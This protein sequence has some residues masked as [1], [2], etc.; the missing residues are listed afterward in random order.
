MQWLT[1]QWLWLLSL[2]AVPVAVHLLR[3][4]ARREI[5]FAAAHWLEQKSSR[6]LRRLLLREPWL[7][8]LRLAALTSLVLLA[9]APQLQQQVA[10]PPSTLLVDPRISQQALQQFLQQSE[11]PER[12]E[13]LHTVPRPI[14]DERPP[15]ENLWHSLSALAYSPRYRYATILLAQADNPT[16]FTALRSSPH[17]QWRVAGAE[18]D[19]EV[20]TPPRIGLIG[21][22]PAWLEPVIDQLAATTATGLSL[23]KLVGIEALADTGTDWLIYNLPG[24]LPE[25]VRRFIGTGGLLITDTRVS[26]DS[27]LA[28]QI[29]STAER[30]EAAPYGRGSWL[31]YR[32]DWHSG[33]FFTDY[34]LPEK[35]WRAWYQQDWQLQHSGIGTWSVASPPSI[36]VDD[37]EISP[38]VWQ[39]YQRQLLMLFVALLALE[40]VLVLS[41]GR[42]PRHREVA[43]SDG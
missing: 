2:L 34:A 24:P 43:D 36:V 14:A 23:R 40:R 41:R 13:W 19:A 35:L 7:L 15:A 17:W 26:D 3:R 31:R 28:F 20:F 9:A 6:S 25:E 22:A 10:A 39:G 12:I 32:G 4:R 21:E 8:L 11:A 38:W 1:P 33:E 30:M 42:G 27:R 5:T 37:E 16:G 18:S 29:L